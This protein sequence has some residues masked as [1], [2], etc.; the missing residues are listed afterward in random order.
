M[1]CPTAGGSIAWNFQFHYFWH[2]SW[3]SE[4]GSK[5]QILQFDPLRALKFLLIKA[6]KAC[7]LWHCLSLAHLTCI[8]DQ[9]IL[10]LEVLSRF[11]QVSKFWAWISFSLETLTGSEWHSFSS[12]S[13]NS[14]WDDFW[15]EGVSSGQM[16]FMAWLLEQSARTWLI[17]WYS[18]NSIS[19]Q[20]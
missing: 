12:Y 17:C 1:N 18:N 15:Q 7:K 19:G 5:A 20:F 16:L 13:I 8:T 4:A 2:S 6:V 3:I 10:T 14:T 11:Q 9:C